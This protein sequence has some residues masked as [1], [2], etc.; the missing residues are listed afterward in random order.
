MQAKGKRFS[1][2]MARLAM[3]T[4]ERERLWVPRVARLRRSSGG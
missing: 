4:A 2:V 3:I 1:T